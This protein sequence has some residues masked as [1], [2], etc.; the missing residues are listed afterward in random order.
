MNNST[1]QSRRQSCVGCGMKLGSRFPLFLSNGV[2]VQTCMP[3]IERAHASPR[4]RRQVE[5]AAASGQSLPTIERLFAQIG[6]FDV[7]VTG[8]ECDE[9]IGL[10]PGSTDAALRGVL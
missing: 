4:F 7:P 6:V 1:K 5:I 8:E 2:I 9:A 3:C 10:P